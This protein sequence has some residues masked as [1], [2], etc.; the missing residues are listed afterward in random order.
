MMMPIQSPPTLRTGNSTPYSE[1]V[2]G[3]TPQLKVCTP[4]IRV[5]G[6][7]W[8]VR[9]PVLGRKCFRVPGLGSWK[10]C[11]RTTWLPPFVRCGLSRC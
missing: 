1:P 6:G 11:C 4:C 9:L 8:C 2:P 3:V 7:R 10:A 5:G